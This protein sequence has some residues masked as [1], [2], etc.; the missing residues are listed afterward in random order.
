MQRELL[1][2]VRID[3]LA[4]GHAPTPVLRAEGLPNDV[5]LQRRVVHAL[6]HADD[7]DGVALLR[8]VVVVEPDSEVPAVGGAVEEEVGGARVRV[9]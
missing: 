2:W 4:Q 7:A 6:D 3:W 8:R 5:G 9:R 1:V